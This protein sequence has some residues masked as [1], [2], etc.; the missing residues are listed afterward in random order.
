MP[1][2]FVVPGAGARRPSLGTTPGTAPLSSHD[3]PL[4]FGADGMSCDR[5]D[6]RRHVVRWEHDA[7][8]RRG[9][10]TQCVPGP[11]AS[12]SDYSHS[13]VPGGFDV[14]SSTTR[15]TS[16]TSFVM[17][18]EIFARVSYGRRVQSAVMASS[19]ETGRSTIGCP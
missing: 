7:R 13:I 9:P 10:G 6:R 16:R 12:G 2:P 15:F 17:R 3:L 14:T 4:D 18:F 5:N 19:D 11:R 1:G 8:T